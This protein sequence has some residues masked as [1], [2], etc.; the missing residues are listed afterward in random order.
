MKLTPKQLDHLENQ[1]QKQIGMPLGTT[2]AVL[3]GELLELITGY[4][5]A[6]VTNEG[7]SN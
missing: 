7:E 3:P 2:V 4:R 6:T 5:K 1:A